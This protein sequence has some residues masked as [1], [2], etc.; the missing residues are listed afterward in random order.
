[1]SENV[2]LRQQRAA[3]ITTADSLVRVAAKEVRA[4][5]LKEAAEV[6]GLLVEAAELAVEIQSVEADMNRQRALPPVHFSASQ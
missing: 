4:L 6:D 3:I 5:T 2:R 1:M